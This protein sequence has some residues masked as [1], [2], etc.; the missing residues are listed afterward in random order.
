MVVVLCMGLPN[1]SRTACDVK[2]SEGMR[3]IKCFCLFFSCFPPTVLASEYIKYTRA[4]LHGEG[5]QGKLAFSIISYMAGSA[6]FKL[7]ASNCCA[8]GWLAR[9]EPEV[10]AK[11]SGSSWRT[12]C[13]LS[14]FSVET[15]RLVA[16][17]MLPPWLRLLLLHDDRTG[18]AARRM[19]REAPRSRGEADMVVCALVFTCKPE[20]H[21]VSLPMGSLDP[22]LG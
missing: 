1:A 9:E 17:A 8:A 10:E 16:E 4:H 14:T 11:V 19:T 20:L 13:W 6:S 7:V 22:G 2:F 5:L 21:G 18:M 12:F 15:H 3:L